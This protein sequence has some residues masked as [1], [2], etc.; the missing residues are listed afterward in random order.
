MDHAVL[1]NDRVAVGSERA[2]Q[3]KLGIDLAILIEL[4]WAQ[5]RLLREYTALIDPPGYAPTQ[6]PVSRSC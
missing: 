1:V 4:T 3:G 6:S 2:P 5:G